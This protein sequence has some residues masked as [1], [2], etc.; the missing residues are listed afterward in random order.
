MTLHDWWNERVLRDDHRHHFTRR[1]IILTVANQDGGAHV[2]PEIDEAYHRLANEHS[3]G[4]I[5][6]GPDGQKPLEHIEKVYVRQIAWELIQSMER[7]WAKVIGNRP[8]A[9]G[10]GRKHRY[11]HGKA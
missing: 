3:I 2:D 5:S 6:V 7:A 8:C 9:C 4:F 11:C 1:D 10:S